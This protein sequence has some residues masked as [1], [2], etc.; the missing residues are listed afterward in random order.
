MWYIQYSYNGIIVD[1]N[2]NK[3]ASYE[4]SLVFFRR[5]GR[6]ILSHGRRD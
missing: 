5:M 1:C 2:Y 3:K 4:D 6:Y